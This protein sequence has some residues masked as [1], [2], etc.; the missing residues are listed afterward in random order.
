MM[1]LNEKLRDYN[2]TCGDYECLYH[3]FFCFFGNLCMSCLSGAR[4]KSEGI[5][6]VIRI[7]TEHLI[8]WQAV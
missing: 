6:K 7:F 3:V 1:T 2:S 4:E 8:L 5:T